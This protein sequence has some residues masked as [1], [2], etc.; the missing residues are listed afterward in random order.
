MLGR[1]ARIAVVTAI[2]VIGGGALVHAL[3]SVTRPLPDVTLA[4]S[5]FAV[6][7][8]WVDQPD[9]ANLFPGETG[10]GTAGVFLDSDASW[11]YSVTATIEGELADHLSAV[12]YTDAGCEGAPLTMGQTNGDTLAGGTETNFCIRFTLDRDTPGMLQNATAD[13][14]VN[15]RAYQVRP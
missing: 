4:T 13:V 11:Q 2:L 6:T 3:W 1:S 9:L 12:W 7:A 15:V 8:E 5:D 14:T 10:S